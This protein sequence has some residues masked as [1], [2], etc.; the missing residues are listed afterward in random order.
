MVIMMT[1]A[2]GSLII[3][4]LRCIKKSAAKHSFFAYFVTIQYRPKHLLLR[5]YEHDATCKNPIAGGDGIF[6]SSCSV[7][8]Q[9]LIFSVDI[10]GDQHGKLECQRIFKRFDVQTVFLFDLIQPVHECI[11]VY[12]KLTRCF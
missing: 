11:A 3:D 4:D 7:S 9:L 8:E 12:V 2:T 1:M 6:A 5:P 10:I